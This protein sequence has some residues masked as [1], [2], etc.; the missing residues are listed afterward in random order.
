MA[1]SEKKIL[2]IKV[3]FEAGKLSRAAIGKEYRVS[4]PTIRLL[5]KEREWEYKKNFIEF[6]EEIEQKT[7][8]SLI[9][10][11]VDKTTKIT[12]QFLSDLD[13]FR[14]L[15]MR[16]A[17]DIVNAYNKL[18]DGEKKGKV[19]KEEFDRIFAGSKVSKINMEALNI[20]YSGAR[21]ALGMDREDDIEKA[22]KIKGAEKQPVVDPTEGIDEETIDKQIKELD[23]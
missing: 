20:G 17:T 14:R 4:Q 15:C 19:L 18:T 1:L 16:S 11:E 3:A 9:E 21:K 8:E 12:A 22:R 13:I 7:I 23:G 6:S 2:K 10:K 5:A